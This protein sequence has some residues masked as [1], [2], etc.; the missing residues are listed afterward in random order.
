MSEQT[1]KE[2][3]AL[4]ESVAEV[5]GWFPTDAAMQAALAKLTLAGY[6]RADFSLP[7][8]H[9]GAVATPTE[10]ADNP[11]DA[12]DKQQ[13]RTMTSGMAAAGA[14]MAVAGVVLTGGV[15][16]A[17]A[18]AGL[19]AA[20]LTSGAGVAAD[21][22]QVQERDQLGAAGRLIL[23]VRTDQPG[24]APQVESIMRDAGATRTMQ[25]TRSD[26]ALTAG[27]SAASWTGG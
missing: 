6:D 2:G 20:A 5:Q 1:G 11:T 16:L 15:G 21:N 3:P 23:A 17:A 24:Q 4:A 25:V 19:G 7:E 13:I 26:T 27:V 14:G 22:T 9:P 18:A 10:G 8:D 12:I